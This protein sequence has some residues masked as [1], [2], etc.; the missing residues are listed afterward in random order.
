M[1]FSPPFTAA[2]VARCVN[3]VMIQFCTQGISKTSPAAGPS[4]AKR[5]D[6]AIWA[7]KVA[8]EYQLDA[9]W[10]KSQLAQARYIPSIS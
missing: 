4:Y 1:A 6:A 5:Q 3:S 10:I 9:K 8:Q 7:D 2:I